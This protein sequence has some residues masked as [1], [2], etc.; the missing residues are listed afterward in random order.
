MTGPGNPRYKGTWVDRR[1]GYRFIRPDLLDEETRALV[2]PGKR[3]VPEHRAVIAKMLGRWPTSRE[4]VHHINGDK[5]DNR[6]ENLTLMDWTA[7]SREHRK[8]LHR[9]VV[10]EEENRALRSALAA[11][12]G[13]GRRT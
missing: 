8:V 7:H 5:L 3:E 2:P 13:D 10:L 4:H 12:K 9:M 6:P 1:T 11:L